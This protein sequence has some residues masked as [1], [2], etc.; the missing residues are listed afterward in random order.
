[1]AEKDNMWDLGRNA[2][3]KS[4]LVLIIVFALYGSVPGVLKKDLYH[5]SIRSAG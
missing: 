2:Q 5:K 4:S 1:M 3:G